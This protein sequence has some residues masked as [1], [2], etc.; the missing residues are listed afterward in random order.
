M[1][2]GVLKVKK[3]TGACLNKQEKIGSQ[4]VC[5]Q[6]LTVDTVITNFYY[7]QTIYQYVAL[8]NA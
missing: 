8:G 3:L 7:R 1:G 6:M 2:T 4:I 5:T